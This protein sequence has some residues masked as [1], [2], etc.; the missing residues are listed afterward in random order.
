MVKEGVLKDPPVDAV[1]GLHV[2]APF[3]SGILYYRSGPLMAAADRFEIVVEG[4]QTHGSAPWNGIDPIVVAAHI[5]DT[6]QTVVS[7]RIDITKEPA[8][9][10]VG[11]FEAGVRNNIIPDRARLVGT[12]RTFDD[13]MQSEIHKR[14]REIAEGVAAA[15]GAK[16]TVTI[17]RGYPVTINDPELT[18]RMLPTLQR[19]AP[20][21]VLESTKV[22]GAEDFT[23]YQRA[24][25]GL[26]FFLGVTPEDQLATAA[27]N[28]SP[29]FFADETALLTGVRALVHLTA[30]YL[31]GAPPAVR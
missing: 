12:I 24:V 19:V 26:F 10:T 2:R 20:G 28:H 25:P 18:A 29:R 6:L 16:A 27:T 15:E 8:V 7:R 1:F 13:A 17:V 5:V 11:Q 31:A 3:K 21:R 23:Y 14:I 4:R 30:D 22:T 9:V